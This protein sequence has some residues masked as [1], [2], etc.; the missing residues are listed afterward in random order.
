MEQSI[1]HEDN[2]IKKIIFN[3]VKDITRLSLYRE[4]VVKLVEKE[5]ENTTTQMLAIDVVLDSVIEQSCNWVR[6]Q[7]LAL[8]TIGFMILH[9]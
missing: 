4:E 3:A 6:R 1:I 2:E 9:A 5:G 8:R 7:Y